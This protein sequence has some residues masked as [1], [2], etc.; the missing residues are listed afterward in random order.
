MI[1]KDWDTGLL[2]ETFVQVMLGVG[3][4]SAMQFS[5]TTSSL[6]TVRLLEMDVISGITLG[7]E[8]NVY[9]HENDNKIANFK[10][11]EL[12]LIS[13]QPKGTAIE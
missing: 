12:L 8:K 2:S 3:L 5:V 6:F 7:G 13:Y 10:A 11:H 1:V 9:N 4:P